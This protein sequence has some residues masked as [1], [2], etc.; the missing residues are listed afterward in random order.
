MRRGGYVSEEAAKVAREQVAA[1][2]K[3]IG[4]TTGHWLESWVRSIRLRR[5]TRRNYRQ[6]VA[7]YLIPQLGDLPLVTLSVGDVR[8][9]FAAIAAGDGSR[10]GR[11]APSTVV[12]VRATLSSA[13]T[14]AVGQGLLAHNPARGREIELPEV[15]RPRPYVWTEARV[16]RW[17]ATGWRPGPV[18]VWTREQTIEFLKAIAGH[19]RYLYYHLVAVTGLRRSEAAALREV[20][21]DLRHSELFVIT[22]P[23]PGEQVDGDGKLKS[24]HSTRTIALDH[25]TASLVRRYLAAR[26]AAPAGPGGERYL[27]TTPAGMPCRLDLFTHEF[28]D[29]LAERTSLPPIRLHDLRHGA[30][31]LSLAA[32]NDLSMSRRCSDMLRCPSPPTTTYRSTRAPATRR[33]RGSARPCSRRRPVACTG[34]GS[35]SVADE[36]RAVPSDAHAGQRL[37]RKSEPADSKSEGSSLR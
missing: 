36:W 1:T 4:L 16:A 22:R 24:Q 27:F 20:D 6:H 17:R 32:G 19:K 14:A 35:C 10:Y 2:S 37:P 23:D 26:V 7:T 9:A 33:R 15:V 5:S 12:R 13:L 25:V 34:P 29:L 11:L 31:S 18:C 21:V 8:K 3:G 30:A 28:E